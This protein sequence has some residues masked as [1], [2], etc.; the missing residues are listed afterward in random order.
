MA[1]TAIEW[2]TKVWNPVLGC[3]P[4]SEGC[5]NC[6]AQKFHNRLR[7]QR[8]PNYQREFWESFIGGPWLAPFNWKKPERIFVCSMGDF[9]YEGHDTKEQWKIW[10]SLCRQAKQLTRHRY[11]VLT[12]R[13]SRMADYVLG[14]HVLQEEPLPNLWLGVTVENQR[15]ADERLPY[16]AKCKADGWHTFV[17]CEPLLE[18]VLLIDDSIWVS[19]E[20]T[21]ITCGR[22]W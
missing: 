22:D 18:E 10:L 12:K 9:F 2:A 21:F 6:Y 7:G 13:A 15:T 3:E 11:L 17:S 16:L 8:H 1:D 4:V 19:G 5:K 14:E 20:E